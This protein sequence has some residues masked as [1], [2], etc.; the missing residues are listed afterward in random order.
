GLAEKDVKKLKVGDIIQF[1]RFAFCRLDKKE[2]NKLV[3][4]FTH[5]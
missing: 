4:W 5:K 1:E 3:F 2:K